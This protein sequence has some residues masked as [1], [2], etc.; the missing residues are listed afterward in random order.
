[1]IKASLGQQ[2]EELVL[3]L[4]EQVLLFE[5]KNSCDANFALEETKNVLGFSTSCEDLKTDYLLSIKKGTVS[6]SLLL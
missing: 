3:L 1:M 6:K 4:Y 2:Y 5:S